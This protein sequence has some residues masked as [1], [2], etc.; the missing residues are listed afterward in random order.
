MNLSTNFRRSESILCFVSSQLTEKSLFCFDFVLTEL[1]TALLTKAR[2]NSN[3]AAL[4]THF[5]RVAD[6][7]TLTLL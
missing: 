2:E 6:L 1:G 7:L 3:D 5:S 4:E